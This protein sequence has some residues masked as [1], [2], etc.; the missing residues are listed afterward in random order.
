MN[1]V[2]ARLN[3]VCLGLIVICLF[4]T[5]LS[6]A[7]IDTAALVGLWFLDEGKGDV[8]KDASDKG[9]DGTMVGDPQWVDTD[10]HGKALKFAGDGDYVEIKDNDSLH[11]DKNDFTVVAWVNPAELKQSGFVTKGAYCWEG[12]WIL[13]M[14]DAAG[15]LRLETC[16][17]DGGAGSLISKPGVMVTD[18][19]QFIA[20]TVTRGKASFLFRD[21][22]EVARTE[23]I[24]TTSDISCP[25]YTLYFASIR[26]CGQESGWYFN[27]LIAEVALFNGLALTKADIDTIMAEGLRSILAVASAGKLSTTWAMIKAQD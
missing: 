8:V 10:E 19:W 5:R 9:N 3:L 14:P 13:D 17:P 7:K 27:G 2:K 1:A 26:G 20:V 22:E 18:K 23:T 11:V 24:D 6:Y 16:A 25:E 15:T 4:F 12:G 21:G